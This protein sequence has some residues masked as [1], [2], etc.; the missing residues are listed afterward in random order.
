M[1]VDNVLEID[2]YG[3]I[4][5]IAASSNGKDTR[6]A[7]PGDVS[8]LPAML[9]SDFAAAFPSVSWGY[10]W[11]C[12]RFSGVPRCYIRA[13]KKVYYNNLHLLRFMGKVYEA[14]VNAS[15]VKTGGPASGTI[16]VLC[17]DPFLRMLQAQR[18]PR[19]IGRSFAD[20][21]GYVIFDIKITLPKF[22]IC[23]RLFGEVSNIQLKIKKTIIVPLWT[24][25]LG[26][27]K[28]IIRH[29]APEWDGACV[30][31]HAKYLGMQLG[32]RSADIIWTAALDKYVARVQAA[33]ATGAG[34]LTSVLEYNIMCVTTLS[35]VGQFCIV[36]PRVLAAEAKM[37][38]RLTGCPR[39]TFSK[40]ALWCLNSMGMMRSFDSV[41][42][43]NIAA[44]VRTAIG[45]S[46]TFAHMKSLLDNA[47]NDDDNLML[48]LVTNEVGT[49]DT[50]A[51]VNTLQRAVDYAFLPDILHLS[52]KGFL[53]GLRRDSDEVGSQRQIARYL[54]QVT[55]TFDAGE[56]FSR[57]MARWRSA[58]SAGARQWWDFSGPFAVHLFNVELKGAP[59]CVI[60]ACLK[61]LLNGWASTRRLQQEQAGCVFGCGSKQDAIE[62]YLECK[63]LEGIWNNIFRVEWGVFECRLAVGSADIQGRILR[64]YFLYGLFAT[65]NLLRHNK[66][67]A[68]PDFCTN[69]IRN[70]IGLALGR[71]S[72]LI[73]HL[74][75]EAQALTSIPSR[76]GDDIRTVGEVIFNFRK[77]SMVERGT[78]K[79]P[80][81]HIKRPRH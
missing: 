79:R 62:H 44:M 25:D 65:Y 19:D 33:R 23:F 14:Y 2:T 7:C 24:G 12:M 28:H 81:T 56:Y 51:I 32:P 5:S 68:T 76:C 34:F 22:V 21:I 49:F 1:I 47:L 60:A 53:K 10:L 13:F 36:E 4:C 41:K 48:S 54:A 20:D 75:N 26:M 64:S 40:E 63:V 59:Q 52:W 37:L 77:R 71:S 42:V 46:T 3:R 8:R 66:V 69:L 29:I 70:K 38:Q 18:G 57:R 27:A 31:L 6:S 30:G 45:T 17:I 74:F 58:T 43:C 50:P 35:Y 61:T 80:R 39:Y 9:F 73:R 11:M 78:S 55:N 15:G 67:N 72:S 16:F